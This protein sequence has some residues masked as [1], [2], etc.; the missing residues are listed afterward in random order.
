MKGTAASRLT[1]G[2]MALMAGAVLALGGAAARADSVEQ[3]TLAHLA[4][5]RAIKAEADEQTL[6]GYNKQMDEA[7]KFFNAN[8]KAVLPVL[9]RELTAEL[10]AARPN[11][12]ILL[13]IGYF[14]R[15]QDEASDQALGKRAL[16]RLDP[17]AATL[18]K[19][20]QELFMFAHLVAPEQ[21]PEVLPFLD[22][23]FLRRDVSLFIPQHALRVDPTLACVFLYGINGKAGEAHL[24]AL[25]A[26]ASVSGP[27]AADPA[28]AN[29]ALINKI[30][31]IMIWTGS[32]DSVPAVKAALLSRRDYDTFVRATAFMMTL[33]GPEGRAI[34]LS[35][36]PRPYDAK[37]RQ[38]YEQTR[39]AIERVSYEQQVKGLESISEQSQPARL[40]DAELKKRLSAM[41]ENYGKDDQTSPLALLNST[42]PKPYLADE[43]MRI[44]ARMFYRLSDE[45]LDDVKVTNQ[46]L[47]ALYYR[48]E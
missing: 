45:A 6:A 19:N 29:P 3:E 23:A 38:Y 1:G 31:E 35:L 15:R 5:L 32:R 14:I 30:I 25:L 26:D 42:L 2:F 37:A 48:H 13:D 16:F 12:M 44:R 27:G 47:N 28:V 43:L 10:G 17:A 20:Q 33:G 8:K 39:S 24:G 9:R 40:G 34:M 7:W 22:R 21:D 4:Q 11:D 41:Y 18:R 46:I 36:D